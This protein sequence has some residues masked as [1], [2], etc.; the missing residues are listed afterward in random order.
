MMI[1]RIK[2]LQENALQDISNISSEDTLELVRQKYL[3]RKSGELTLLMKDI[4]SLSIDEKRAIGPIVNEAKQKITTSLDEKSS[5]L[6]TS[7][8]SKNDFFDFTLPGHK[9]QIGT[10]HPITLV[11]RQVEEIFQRMG[12]EVLEPREVDDDYHVFTSL[13][14]PPEHPARDMW[15]TFWTDNDFIPITHTSS[16]QNRAL[17]L[18]KPPFGVIIPGRCFRHEATDARH[19]HTFYQVEGLYV[20]EGINLG[21]LISTIL[22]FLEAYFGKKLKYK[23]QPSYFP[24]VEPGLEFL[25][26]CVICDGKGEVDKKP[27]ST[28]GHSGWLEL[29][30]C[31]MTHPKVIEMGGLDPKKYSGFAWGMGLD[32][33]VMLKYG[34]EDIRHFHSG[35]IKFLKQF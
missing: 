3:G 29:I 32:R 10:I 22:T 26:S 15:D 5:Q 34:I 35:N 28:C 13:N 20:G 30:P 12:F 18:K 21:H 7:Q 27:C 16:M 25:V 19:E 6:L 24:F 17:E 11:R 4:P 14:L 8:A 9:P 2:S 33:L 1:D 31:G 23:I